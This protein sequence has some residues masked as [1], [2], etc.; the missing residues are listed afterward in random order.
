[1][2]TWIPAPHLLTPQD[3]E[4][5]LGQLICECLNRRL[6]DLAPVIVQQIETLCQHPDYCGSWEERCAYR[7]LARYW[8]RLAWIAADSPVYP[9]QHAAL[10]PHQRVAMC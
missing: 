9:S 6:T 2:N 7:R 3:I 4:I 8:N 5:Q 1:M 10:A